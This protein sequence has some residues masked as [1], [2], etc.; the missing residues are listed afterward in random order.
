[1]STSNK[2]LEFHKK[3]SKLIKIN[4]TIIE[5]E[6]ENDK[7]D[8]ARDILSKIQIS[9]ISNC[10]EKM[11]ICIAGLYICFYKAR[12]QRLEAFNESKL[13][14]RHSRWCLSL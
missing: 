7:I 1:M 3:I 14:C 2:L 10:L 6:E 11:K 9:R 13:L 5:I 4:Q 12:I 8:T